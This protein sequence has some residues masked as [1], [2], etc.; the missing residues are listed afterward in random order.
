MKAADRNA[1]GSTARFVFM[2]FSLGWSRLLQGFDCDSEV[3]PKTLPSAAV[4]TISPLGPYRPM[5]VRGFLYFGV[6]PRYRGQLTQPHEHPAHFDRVLA[7]DPPGLLGVGELGK[8]HVHM[9]V[10]LTN[11]KVP[12]LDAIVAHAAA[13]GVVEEREVQI[14]VDP[15]QSVQRRLPG[16][17]EFAVDRHSDLPARV[18]GLLNAFKE[19]IGIEVEMLNPLNRMRPSSKFEP[20]FL[21]SVAPSLGVGVGLAMRRVDF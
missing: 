13:Q 4:L 2:I 6:C 11:G 19:R 3:L 10:A 5:P 7:F 21:E 15:N 20:E 8:K 9:V 12:F 18:A 16:A 1:N 14:E 17:R